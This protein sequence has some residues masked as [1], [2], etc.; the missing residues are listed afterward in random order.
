MAGID[1]GNSELSLKQKVYPWVIVIGCCFMQIGGIGTF[2][3]SCGV[4]YVAAAD[5]LGITVGEYSS[6]MTFIFVGT[7]FAAVAMSLVIDRID[8]RIL[9]SVNCVICAVALAFMGYYPDMLW[10]KVAGFLFGFNGGFFFMTMTPILINNW[11]VRKKGLAMGIAMCSSGVG[12]AIL[13]PFVTYLIQTIGWQLAYVVVAAIVLILILPFSIFVFR[14]RPAELGLKPYGWDQLSEEAEKKEAKILKAGVPYKVA[15]V[16]I[17]FI[18][19]CCAVGCIAI[20]SPFNSHLNAFGQSIGYTAMV[21][22]TF[23][24][25]VSLGS[26][27]EKLIM[28]WLYDFISIYKI[29]AINFCLLAIGL[30]LLATQTA[31]PLLYLGAFL[32]GVQNSLVAVQIP[33]LV[34]D[35]FGDRPYDRLIPITRVGVGVFGLF[36]PIII[37]SILGATGG[38]AAVWGT[39]ILIVIAAALF[40]IIARATRKSPQAAW[41]EEGQE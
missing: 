16:S 6:Y 19:V 37:T 38:Y 32:F 34:R 26:I 31:L 12:A 41:R 17:S 21:S 11:F 24:T 7:A 33:L 27:C 18:C 22:S 28:G 20:F 39:G 9:I 25:A 15:V 8:I 3:D 14:R 4:F 10:R 1:T 35:L 36:G 29:I 13:S 2:L 23:L 30:A 5:G 40:V